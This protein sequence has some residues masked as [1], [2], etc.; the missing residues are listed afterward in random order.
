M[1]ARNIAMRWM[2]AAA[3]ILLLTLAGACSGPREE[4]APP[5]PPPWEK[6]DTGV[7]VSPAA[8]QAKKI[9]L[10]VMNDAVIR[11]TVS[12][13][14]SLDP[15]KSLIVRAAPTKVPFSVVASG[16]TLTLK[17]AKVS[18]DVSL[19][20]GK[21]VF[22]DAAGK[23]VL[24]GHDGG[25]FVPVNVD[26]KAFYAV[27][28]EFNRGTDEGFYGL[29]QHQNGQMNYNGED[30]ILAQHNMDVAV[31][32]VVSTNNYGVLWDNYSITRFGY[33]KEYDTL[34]KTLKLRAADGKDGGLTARYYDGDKLL[35]ERVEGDP[36]YQFIPDQKNFPE[37]VKVHTDKPLPEGT[38]PATIKNLKVVYD[39]TLETDKTGVHKFRFY[40]SGYFKLWIDGKL[41]MDSWRQG[42][43]GWYRN[44]EMEMTAGKPVKFHAEWRNE[45]N[46]YLRFLHLDPLPDAERHELSLSSDVA[47][48]IDYYYIAADDM[49]GV[50]AGYRQ[51][52]GEAPLLPKWAYGF[53]QSRQRY[54]TQDQ[55]V[56]V[57]KEYRKLGVPLDAIVQD[58]RYWKDPDWGSHDFDETRFP[59]PQKMVDDVHALHAKLMIVIWPKFYPHLANYKAFDEKGLMYRY[60]VEQGYLDWVGP[61]Y[62]SSN[63]DAYSQEARD[64]YWKQIAPKLDA[65]GPDS[66]WMDND[67]PD[68][69]SNM[70]IDDQIKMRG[71]TVY[72][73]GA[74]VYNSYPLEHVCGFY[75]HWSAAHPDQRT[76]ILTRSGF[77]GLQRCSAGVWS[78]DIAARWS[79]MREQISAGVNF[80][81]SGIPTWS[82][83]IGGYT[84]EDRYSIKPNKADKAEWTELYTRWY[85]FGAFAPIF[86]SHGELIKREIYEIAKPGSQTFNILSWYTRLRYRLLPYIYSAAAATYHQSGT[87]MRGLAMDFAYD[88]KTWNVADEYMFGKS[89]LVAPVSAYK[90]TSRP[91]YLPAG[92]TWYDFFTGKTYAGGQTVAAAAPLT[93]SPLFVKAGAIVATGPDV[94]Y[95]DQKP[96]A[97]IVFVVYTGA[98]G[99]AE[100]YEDDGASNAYRR[101]KWSS[102][103]LSYDEATG[104]LTIGARH[105]S[106]DG[107]AAKRVFK[108]RFISGPTKTAAD[109]DAKADA[110]VAYDGRE[111]K[112][113]KPKK[114]T[115][116]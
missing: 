109:F 44:Y 50:I 16:D 98:S 82:F 105:G 111:L 76:F 5:P 51:L 84:T 63:Y 52:T 116:H 1:T 48:V 2:A 81:L 65:L 73:P 13:D 19:T 41:V 31:P 68:I 108:V 43:Q 102:I 21:I 95:A 42:W 87:I 4:K 34:S 26:G 112:I 12:P 97:P 18:A 53:W 38:P 62:M 14:G 45:G 90:A 113:A 9:R 89:F 103:P 60:A 99:K 74:L 59:N 49:D 7:I 115:V 28:Q 10:V 33:P 61:G 6:T 25:Q 72:G 15:R 70:P 67:E 40:V 17:T 110:T 100:L 27:R 39:G 69:H 20:T 54:E 47:S 91:V 55:L 58:W 85:Q 37:A 106:Y 78:G 104:A 24:S 79:D 35:A 8:S 64:I 23:A 46:A 101:G 11:V 36:N 3:G 75:D 57:V 114:P 29:G 22:R 77:A 93:H 32:M 83:D 96:N 88:R 71:P 30:V 56:G 66:W 80:S 107:M 92:V 86:R 94:Q